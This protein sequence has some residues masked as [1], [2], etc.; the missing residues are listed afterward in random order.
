MPAPQ[1]PQP[2]SIYVVGDTATLTVSV[3]LPDTPAAGSP[4]GTAPTYVD[5]GSITVRVEPPVTGGTPAYTLTYGT[6]AALSRVSA[7]VYRVTIPIGLT[8]IGK[9]KVRIRSTANGSNQGAGAREWP[10][11]VVAS[12]LASP[13]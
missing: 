13:Q 5:P 9:W 4:L 7:G 10:F 6:D 1:L 11:Q 3:T 8:D 12:T 2:I